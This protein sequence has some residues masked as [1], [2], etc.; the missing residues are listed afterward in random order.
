[1]LFEMI[2][3][4]AQAGAQIIC[5][6]DDR[7]LTSVNRSGMFS[8]LISQFGC[9]ETL[10][11]IEVIQRLRHGEREEALA[12]ARQ[13]MRTIDDKG[14]VVRVQEMPETKKAPARPPL[15]DFGQV[16][17]MSATIKAQHN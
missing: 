13:K 8:Q 16:T 15:L 9:K 5:A 3:A 12:H 6:G 2:R 4:A 11:R 17:E 7:Q 10:A 14:N 1:M